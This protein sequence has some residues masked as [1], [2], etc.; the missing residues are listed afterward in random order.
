M[1][2]HAYNEI[3]RLRWSRLKNVL[4][5]PLHFL[6]GEDEPVET[7]GPMRLGT[8]IHAA[9]L[10]PEKFAQA[11]PR[12]HLFTN[13]GALSTAKGA[14]EE[15]KA[16][17]STDPDAL[18]FSTAQR[19]MCGRIVDLVNCHEDAGLWLAESPQESREFE[20]LWTET[21]PVEG[22]IAGPSRFP[23]ARILDGAVEIDCKG[24]PDFHCPRMGLLGDLKSDGKPGFS[25]RRCGG[26]IWAEAQAAQVAFYDRGMLATG[27]ISEPSTYVFIYVSARDGFEDVIPFELAN[28]AEVDDE[29]GETI[30]S[31]SGDE[32]RAEALDALTKLA[33]AIAFDRWDGVA[34]RKVALA[35]PSWRKANTS[36]VADLGLDF[37][38]ADGE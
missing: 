25:V 9:V 13:G 28:L 21:I 32:A 31:E 6:Q 16:L 12:D 26:R 29:S 8:T 36:D 30:A 7:T 38:G 18:V 10:E 3:P 34:P 35:I 19:D 15:L 14:K 1:S 22:A 23:W 11:S 37:G 33:T 27:R 24:M 5:S 4:V 17:E 20:L 2:T